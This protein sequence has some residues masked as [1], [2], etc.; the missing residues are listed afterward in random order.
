MESRLEPLQLERKMLN[1]MYLPQRGIVVIFRQVSRV[2]AAALTSVRDKPPLLDACLYKDLSE[3]F[4][5]LSF[6]AS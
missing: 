5:A 3:S 1:Q 2:L 4:R 6:G